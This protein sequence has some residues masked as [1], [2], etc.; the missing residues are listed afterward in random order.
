MTRSL[1]TTCAAAA[2]TGIVGMSSTE[3][4]TAAGGSRQT[5]SLVGC[6]Q[7]TNPGTR[8]DTGAPFL[9]T[10][11]EGDVGTLVGLRPAPGVDLASHVNHKIEVTGTLYETAA[12]GAERS[13]SIPPVLAVTAARLISTSCP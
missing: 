13:P 12:N 11:V 2:L 1:T 8:A 4:A 5:V 7:E 6:V 9:L 3:P 10:D